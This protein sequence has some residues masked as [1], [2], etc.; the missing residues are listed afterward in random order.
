MSALRVLMVL[1]GVIWFGILRWRLRT[2]RPRRGAAR[3]RRPAT[4]S[5][6]TP[7]RLASSAPTP[8]ADEV[9]RWLRQR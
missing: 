3:L 7:D 9:E 1:L 5:R 4:A 8:L 6:A 2:P